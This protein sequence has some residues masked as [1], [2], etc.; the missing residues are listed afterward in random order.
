MRRDDDREQRSF[1]TMDARGYFDSRDAEKFNKAKNKRKEKY[2][3]NQRRKH[4]R[5]ED[6][7]Y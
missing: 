5:Y 4:D 6:D 2:N 7:F 1:R 3:E